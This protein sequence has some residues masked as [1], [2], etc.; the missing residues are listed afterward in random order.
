MSHSQKTFKCFYW[1]TLFQW[2]NIDETIVR[3][4]ER[5]IHFP[6]FAKNTFIFSKYELGKFVF[7]GNY[8][9]YNECPKWERYWYHALWFGFV[10]QWR[11]VWIT[12]EWWLHSSEPCMSA[13]W[14]DRWQFMQR[15][16]SLKIS[17]E[18]HFDLSRTG[19]FWEAWLKFSDGSCMEWI[20]L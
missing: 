17:F 14:G 10:E 11:V 12:L 1:A 2:T 5:P 9:M 20:R 3:L 6:V 18:W 16:E 7:P 8:I 15:T 13:I 4:H 19:N